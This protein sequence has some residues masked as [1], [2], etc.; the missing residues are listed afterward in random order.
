VGFWVR[1]SE[2][3]VDL[4]QHLLTTL[5]EWFTTEWPFDGVVHTICQAETRQAALLSEAGLQR[6]AGFTLEDGRACWA[7]PWRPR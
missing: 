3:A 4:D 7:Y 5:H 2:W 6:S 1:T